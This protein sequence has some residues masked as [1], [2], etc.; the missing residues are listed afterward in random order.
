MTVKEIVQKYLI[1]GEEAPKHF[2]DDNTVKEFT[3]FTREK[4]IVCYEL[5]TGK[6]VGRYKSL[7]EASRETGVDVSQISKIT[8]GLMRYAGKSRK[9][10]FKR[11]D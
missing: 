9:L 6:M 11:A 5:E 7:T 4:T 8:R 3:S 2:S 1:E 10:V